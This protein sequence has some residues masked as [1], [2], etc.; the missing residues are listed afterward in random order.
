MVQ[1]QAQVP[2]PKQVSDI[3]TEGSAGGSFTQHLQTEQIITFNIISSILT[4][5]SSLQAPSVT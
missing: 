3:K 2:F 5:S 4:I 1:E